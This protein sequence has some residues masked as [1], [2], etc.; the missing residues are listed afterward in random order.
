MT[1]ITGFNAILNP[2][3]SP[4]LQLKPFWAI[5]ILSLVVSLVITL[6]YKRFTNQTLLK[7]LKED[8][9]QHQKKIKEHKDNPQKIGELQKQALEA[10]MQLMK[11]S[12]KPTIITL[13]PILLI[14]GWVSPHYTFAPLLPYA[15][16]DVVLNMQQGIGGVVK[17]IAPE[18]VQMSE[19]QTITNGQAT[20]QISAKQGDHI[21]QFKLNNKTYDKLIHITT[22][23]ES[24]EEIKTVDDEQVKKITI[25]YQKLIVMDLFGWQLGWI[26]SY[27]I[28]S[29]AFS[30]IF[31]KVLRVQ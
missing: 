19:N 4:L 6:V 26:G 21:V 16:F 31:R 17:G 8:M 7:Q 27:I 12:F 9:K 5:L 2:I 22:L 28:W 1:H 23:P 13:L 14:F 18:G 3:L 30:I 11:H 29:I 20:F 15:S 25:N 24:L 10:N